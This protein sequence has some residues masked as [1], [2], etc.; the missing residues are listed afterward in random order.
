VTQIVAD[1]EAEPLR[2]LACEYVLVGLDERGRCPECGLPIDESLRAVGG[3]SVRRL[4]IARF[5]AVALLVAILPWLGFSFILWAVSPTPTVRLVATGC[6]ALHA[7]ALAVAAI[8]GT[9]A[10]SRQRK[11]TR[12][13]IVG[14]LVG[15]FALV[16]L[17]VSGMVLRVP[18]LVQ[19]ADTTTVVV[20]G[21]AVRAAV[22]TITMWFQLGALADILRFA[23]TPAR[24]VRAAGLLAALPWLVFLI[25]IA[26]DGGPPSP[27][28][29]RFGA[30]AL[31]G[32]AFLLASAGAIAMAII[33]LASRRIALRT[34]DA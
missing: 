2:C 10:A 23:S 29:E 3:W 1:A 25:A 5:A 33:S 14:T 22:V 13:A 34:A 18:F 30:L 17:V 11:P 21:A 32:D 7:I 20:L 28:F 6:V 31:W 4:R 26:F 19:I 24:V 9:V 12:L 27:R 15:T 8:A 16:A